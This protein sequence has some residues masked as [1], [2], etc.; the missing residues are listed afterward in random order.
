MPSMFHKKSNLAYLHLP[1]TGGWYVSH[2]LKKLG[3]QNI[4]MNYNGGHVDVKHLPTDTY[5]FGFVRHPVSWYRSLFNFFSNSNW[6]HRSDIFKSEDINQFLLKIQNIKFTNINLITT[7]F[8]V[9]TQ[10]ANVIPSVVMN[11]LTKT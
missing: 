1:K 8:T 6:D 11:Y 2:I 3:F 9:L 7:I 4:N 10:V 5:T